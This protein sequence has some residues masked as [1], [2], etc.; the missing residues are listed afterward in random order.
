MR[1][2]IRQALP[3]S[4][5]SLRSTPADDHLKYIL[6]MEEG[7]DIRQ[8]V[9]QNTIEEVKD[10]KDE[11]CADPCVICLEPV[12]ERAV[13]SPCRH[14]NFDFLCLVSWLQERS[15]CPLCV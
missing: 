10:G 4:A 13:A 3:P 5:L 7:Q 15:K 8:R 2:V 1:S 14:Y 6:Y 11:D 12:S 9:L